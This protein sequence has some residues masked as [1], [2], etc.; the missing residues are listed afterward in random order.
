[1]QKET[2]NWLTLLFLACVWG[3]SFILMKRGMIDKASGD[4]IFSNTQVGAL[5]MAL[6]GLALG[7]FAFQHLS[8][9]KNLKTVLS[10][11]VVGFLG[12]FIPAF[13]FTYAETE[14]SSG[15]A[16]ML[17]S[18][19]P[20]FTLLI[21]MIVF[22]QRLNRLQVV[23]VVIGAVGIVWL[24]MAG[25]DLSS[26]G[27][28]WHIL[29]I[30]LATL[31]YATSVNTIKNNLQGIKPFAIT[32]MAFLFTLLPAL[33]LGW[34]FGVQDTLSSNPHALSG[35]GYISI[36][37][38]VGTALAVI[39]F[40]QLIANSTA[41]F[42]SSVTYFIPMVAVLFGMLDGERITVYQVLAM[43]VILAGVYIANKIAVKRV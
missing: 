23:G 35:L 3:S 30:V 29:A 33:V 41:L 24:M 39:I 7:P 26:S 5:R 16:G 19:T 8:K 14:L 10:I 27:S 11:M 12:N 1:M 9:I 13:M 18:F 40:N 21:G 28:W 6:A 15:Y 17:N 36:L 20:I 37:S 31:C 32:S 42:A 38:L 25:A 43:T 34:Y 2:K 22:Q 4:E